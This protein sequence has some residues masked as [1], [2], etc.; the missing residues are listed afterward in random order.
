ML[1][2][3]GDRK[4]PAKEAEKTSCP[5]TQEEDQKLREESVSGGRE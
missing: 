1:K 3:K 5:M 2:G 4:E